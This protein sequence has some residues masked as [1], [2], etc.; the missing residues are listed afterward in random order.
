MKG[1]RFAE[2]MVTG[3]RMDE[4]SINH[5]LLRRRGLRA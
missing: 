5:V 2:A 1:S 3:V 4:N